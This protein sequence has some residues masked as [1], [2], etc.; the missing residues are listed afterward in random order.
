MGMPK[1]DRLLYILNLLRS[2]RNLNAEV[3]AQECGVTERSIYRDMV[4][5]SEAN[6]PIYYDNGYKLASDNFL[7]PLNFDFDEYLV[8]KTTLEASPL[9]STGKY[10]AVIKRL[11]AKLEASIPEPVRRRSKFTPPATHLAILSSVEQQRCEKCYGRIET[12]I[13]EHRCLRIKYSSIQTGP[14]ERI[15]EPY[16]IIFRGKA[17]YFV[18]FC[19]QREAFRTFRLDRVE[20]VEL[21]EEHFVRQPEIDAET[22]F[23]G[24]WE[25][26]SGIPTEIK[27]RM[28]G[29]A[30]RVVRSGKHHPD[31][32]IEETGDG[33]VIYSVVTRGIDEIQR[34]ILGFGA[35]VEVLEPQQL[36]DRLHRIG[37]FYK[38]TY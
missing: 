19:R 31:E 5:L 3:L 9:K 8:L 14:S 13:N 12:A 20:S 37:Q 4:A 1:Y 23:D 16:F 30:A 6:I 33:G 38:K 21:L 29:A 22:Y 7:P 35:D 2:R 26:Y 11:L 28:K 10:R 36:R 24:S 17:F 15:V 27:I 18:G 34:W 25:V 32:K